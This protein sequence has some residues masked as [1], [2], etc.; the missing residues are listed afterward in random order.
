VE[1]IAMKAVT[2]FE[3]NLLRVLHAIF[4]RTP[5]TQVVPILLKPRPRP[6]CLSR[7]ALELI[8]DALAK[9]C[10]EFLARHGW[11]RDR[12]LRDGRAVEGR[13][14]ERTAPTELGLTFSGFALEFLIQLTAGKLGKSLPKP[15]DL[16][17]G[18]RLLYF[19]AFDALRRTE[20]AKTLASEWTPLHQDGLCRLAF[21]EEVPE[22]PQRFRIE[23]NAWTTGLGAA[24]LESLQ[25]WL[26]A[27]WFEV[28]RKKQTFAHVAR[29]RKL[30]A[31]QTRVLGEFLDALETAGRRDLARCFLDAARRLLH[32][33]PDAR[34]WVGTLDL[35]SERLA[36]RRVIYLDALAF[37]RQMDRLQS[38]QVQA[39]AVGYFDE[40][41]HASQLWKVDW[42][43]LEGDRW[44]RQASAIMREV[45]PL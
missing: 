36:D 34:R 23:W 10:V 30:G 3:A 41:Y 15:A 20:R 24:I 44:C 45:E 19:L 21:L 42:D 26:A 32:D 1:A 2:R 6:P 14:W 7:D 11:M 37:L 31:T 38:W 5:M 43:R 28:E 22:G 17:I 35:K 13:L 39:G 29:V 27:R 16:T 40:G 9:G 25:D 33:E 12:F 4:Q 18:D 8:G